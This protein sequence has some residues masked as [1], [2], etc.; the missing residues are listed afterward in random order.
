M[1]RC[2]G[3][4]VGAR[5]GGACF[6]VFAS[7][8]GPPTQIAQRRAAQRQRGAN[9]AGN[10]RPD[11]STHIASRTAIH[12]AQHTQTFAS[13]IAPTEA[14]NAR[15]AKQAGE[16]TDRPARNLRAHSSP[17]EISKDASP[18]QHPA[19]VQQDLQ[20]Q[21]QQQQRV[22]AP[23]PAG[24]AAAAAHGTR[25]ARRRRR[26]AAGVCVESPAAL[27]RTLCPLRRR[28]RR[29][30]RPSSVVNTIPRSHWPH[31]WHL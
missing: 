31:Y 24:G 28:R 18:Q 17:R 21:R 5:L 7:T 20:H 14:V 13:S 15:K 10:A 2:P 12:A 6:F 9:T 19:R 30:R 16:Q 3:G 29:R 22:R 4:C 26:A 25:R 1:R 27:R 11:H 23:A 8:H